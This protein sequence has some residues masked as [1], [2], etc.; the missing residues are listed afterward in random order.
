MDSVWDI[1]DLLGV[2]RA[3]GADRAVDTLAARVAAQASLD[4]AES[5]ARLLD[6]LACGRAR[7]DRHPAGPRSRPPRR[8]VGHVGRR[9]P[10]RGPGRGRSGTSG[11]RLAARVAD[12]GMLDILEPATWVLR[13][14]REAGAA[15]IQTLAG[16]IAERAESLPAGH[17][18]AAR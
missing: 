9:L 11:Q 4:D 13:A 5:L 3:A 1:A 16:R 14:L 18:R 7:C 17:R 12:D 2:L 6:E 8:P 10:D 15:D